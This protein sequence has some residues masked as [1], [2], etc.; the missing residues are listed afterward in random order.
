MK[1]KLGLL[2]PVLLLAGLLIAGCAAQRGAESAMD[3]KESSLPTGGAVLR[4]GTTHT[5]VIENGKFMPASLEV[6]AGD[7]VEWVNK[8]S[9]GHTITTD[10][11]SVDENLPPGGKVTHTFADAGDVAYHCNFHHTMQGNVVVQ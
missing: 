1:Q 2:V 6:Q 3:Q 9:M 10:D 5:V 8:D 7:T 4:E 11:F